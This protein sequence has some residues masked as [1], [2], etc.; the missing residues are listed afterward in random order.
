MK[1]SGTQSQRKS[2]RVLVFLALAVFPPAILTACGSLFHKDV[3][4]G[5]DAAIVEI[6]AAPVVS[7]EPIESAPL[8]SVVPVPV[9]R[10]DAGV[11]HVDAGIVDA[12]APV[13]VLDSGIPRPLPSG[14]KIPT[15]PSGMRIPSGFPSRFLPH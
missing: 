15:I 8:A 1:T 2:G 13:V 7:V 5:A 9:Y 4:A 11:K 12:A 3:D 14:M 6:D 10:T